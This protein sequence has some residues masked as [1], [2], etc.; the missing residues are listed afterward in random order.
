MVLSL[1]NCLPCL[2]IVLGAPVVAQVALVAQVADAPPPE[3]TPASGRAVAN[4]WDGALGLTASLRPQYPGS[5]KRGFKAAPGFYFR[6]GRFVVTNASG[7]S[8]R[9]TEDVVRGLGVEML[10]SEDVRM[11]LSLRYD[12]GRSENSTPAY[13]GLGNIRSTVR[14]RL[15]ASWKLRG[16]YSLGA[17]WNEDALGRGNGGVGDVSASWEHRL[18]PDSLLTLNTSLSLADGLYMQAYYGVTDAQSQR[19]AYAPYKTSAGL[20]DVGLYAGLRH[21]FGLDWIALAGASVTRLMGSAGASPI[22]R[23]RKG[24]GVSAGLARQF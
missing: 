14:A 2:L 17:S 23:D 18:T 3:P 12:G 8:A 13:A 9:R 5:P 16:P 7:F 6:Y 1:R 11:S 20:R 4:A 15:A 19:S 21:D 22:T 24:F 10:R